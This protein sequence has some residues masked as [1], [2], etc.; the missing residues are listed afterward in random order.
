MASH[1]LQD[2]LSHLPETWDPDC[3]SLH[4]PPSHLSVKPGQILPASTAGT[5]AGR[6]ASPTHP[7]TPHQFSHHISRS[8]SDGAGLSRTT[9]TTTATTTTS[10]NQ[11]LPSFPHSTSNSLPASLVISSLPA[12]LQ[13]SSPHATAYITPATPPATPTTT[14][15]CSHASTS[16]GTAGSMY[17]ASCSTG[18]TKEEAVRLAVLRV[19]GDDR[20]AW[21]FVLKL[22]YPASQMRRPPV[23]WWVPVRFDVPILWG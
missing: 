19:P 22:L 13:N 2:V 7:S 15:P 16:S 3:L 23:T 10:N 20:F 5:A 11:S 8:H 14:A 12:H 21:T 1:L 6:P 4:L 9:S 18:S 17:G